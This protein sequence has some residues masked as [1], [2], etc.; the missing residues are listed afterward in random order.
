V[1]ANKVVIVGLDLGGVTHGGILY[2]GL[3]IRLADFR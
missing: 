3:Q 1:F 2:C